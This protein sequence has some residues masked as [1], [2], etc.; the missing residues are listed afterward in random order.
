M[1]IPYVLHVYSIRMICGLTPRG[2]SLRNPSKK[3]DN[4]PL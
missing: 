2:S 3:L 1:C 4:I